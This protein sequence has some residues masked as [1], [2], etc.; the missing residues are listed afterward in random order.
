MPYFL[1]ENNLEIGQPVK[2]SIDE[3][4]HFLLSRRT[5]TGEQVLVQGPDG[6]RF[7]AVVKSISKKFAGISTIEKISP[8]D[9][10]LIRVTLIQAMIAEKALDFIL[11]K[12]TE[13]GA[14]A[15][16]LF[17]S[18]RTPTRI[19]FAVFEKKKERWN[20]ILWEAAKQSDR[21]KIPALSFFPE[22]STL[23]K[24]LPGLERLVILDR[25]AE[26]LAKD[27]PKAKSLGVFVG[28]EGGFT[29]KESLLLKSLP[30]TISGSLGSGILRAETAAIASIALVQV[31]CQ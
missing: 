26:V 23:V 2:F 20:K 25:E 24:K 15:I 10:P 12:A 14:S 11:Q 21:P 29:Q 3:M 1:S 5:K 19:S 7:K 16:I 22:L 31:L 17:N 18:E 27:L 9:E 13:L 30:N 4:R 6:K 8:P 28:P